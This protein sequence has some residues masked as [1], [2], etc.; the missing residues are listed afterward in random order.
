[1]VA[2]FLIDVVLYAITTIFMNI[3]NTGNT[4]SQKQVIFVW[5][6]ASVLTVSDVVFSLY[7]NRPIQYCTFAVL[8]F[9]QNFVNMPLLSPHSTCGNC[10]RRSFWKPLISHRCSSCG[11]SIYSSDADNE[12]T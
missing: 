5:R 4:L 3:G 2:W 11:K 1:M 6:L 10:G 8:L 7:F 9:L 12:Q